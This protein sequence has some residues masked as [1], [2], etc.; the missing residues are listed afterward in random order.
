[1]S[2]QC[3]FSPAT[4]HARHET[5][6]DF[7]DAAGSLLEH[8]GTPINATCSVT[9][10]KVVPAAA[11]SCS[12]YFLQYK[13]HDAAAG[14]TSAE[15][16]VPVKRLLL[17]CIWPPPSA[18]YLAA[19]IAHKGVTMRA[20]VL[21]LILLECPVD[22]DLLAIKHPAVEA[23]QGEVRASVIDEGHEAVAGAHACDP[24][25]DHLDLHN[26][27]QGLENFLHTTK[28]DACL[29]HAAQAYHTQGSIAAAVLMQHPT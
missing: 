3:T 18:A 13:E 16:P 10:G 7:A 25:L 21:S 12:Q 8:K 27:P 19:E 9:A 23:L 2:Q 6:L 24:V 4:P 29:L 20:G 28:H 26:W 17:M 1:M 5:R 22:A 11:A 15:I 14:G